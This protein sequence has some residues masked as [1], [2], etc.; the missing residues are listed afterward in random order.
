MMSRPSCILAFS[1]GL[2]TSL[3]VVWLREELGY[4][5]VTVTVDT[6]GFDDEELQRIAA[7]S[8]EAGAIEHLVIDGLDELWEDWIRHI[9]ASNYMKGGLYPLCVGVERVVQARHLVRIARERGAAAVAHGSTGAGNDQIRFDV[10][11][12]TLA[13]DL[14]VHAPIRQLGWGRAEEA[15]YLAEHGMHVD[16]STK[17]YSVNAGLWGVTIGGGETRTSHEAVPDHVYATTAAPAHAPE[18]GVTL[19]LGFHRGRL[20]T[21]DGEEGHPVALLR[22]LGEHAAAHGVGRG[23][24]LGDTVLGIKGRIAFE[25]PAA[26][27]LIHAHRELE[28][29]VLTKWQLF[30]KE[31]IAQFYGLFL[32]EG[33]YLDPAMRD[34]EAF[35]DSSQQRVSGNV[36]V[37]LE[38]GRLLVRALQSPHSLMDATRAAYGEESGLWD[39]R[40]AEGFAKIL[41]IQS[42]L[43]HRAGA[44]EE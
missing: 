38:Q 28:K 34:I 17:R 1:G 44:P 20:V 4:D 33:R 9:V 6:G 26:H 15:E 5:V 11:L 19:A 3:C 41:S 32:H 27:V 42:A 12:R 30:V 22:S 7:R 2:D 14:T 40:D 13:P 37:H 31:Q 36:T 8:R 21:L 18:G 39:G 43:A 24:H 16:A 29:L 23:I 35:L 10:V 25:A